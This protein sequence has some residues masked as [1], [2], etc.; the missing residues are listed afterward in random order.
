MKDIGH[1]IKL[2]IDVSDIC[3]AVCE[4]SKG[5]KTYIPTI[6]SDHY[7]PSANYYIIIQFSKNSETADIYRLDEMITV[8]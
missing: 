3:R 4:L 1:I 5:Q 6:L 8:I 7:K 2:I